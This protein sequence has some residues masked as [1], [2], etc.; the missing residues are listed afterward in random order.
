M[1]GKTVGADGSEYHSKRRYRRRVYESVQ[2]IARP[3]LTDL[4]CAVYGLGQGQSRP[5]QDLTS[6]GPN[7]GSALALTLHTEAVAVVT[8]QP[9]HNSTK[10]GDSHAALQTPSLIFLFTQRC[11]CAVAVP[12]FCGVTALN[13]Q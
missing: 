3:A 2:Q 11:F 9:N 10:T 4:T 6:L 5:G 1:I 13:Q 7:A 12:R 8:K